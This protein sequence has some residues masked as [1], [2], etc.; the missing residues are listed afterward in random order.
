MPILQA[1]WVNFH[2]PQD[3]RG[4]EPASLIGLTSGL[5]ASLIG[6]GDF[7]QL[8]TVLFLCN[9][10]RRYR[11]G[12]DAVGQSGKRGQRL[13]GGYD[14]S[15]EQVPGQMALWAIEWDALGF[16]ALGLARSLARYAIFGTIGGLLGGLTLIALRRAGFF[17]YL[18][19]KK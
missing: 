8:I 17:A 3:E 9:G 13:P 16:V 2:Y 5:L 1:E 10:L 18:A 6:V 7:D 12:S 4:I 14:R 15:F 11:S 19:D